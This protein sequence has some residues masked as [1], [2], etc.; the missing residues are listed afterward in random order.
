MKKEP[1]QKKSSAA[2]LIRNVIAKSR[3]PI[4]ARSEKQ[5]RARDHKNEE[6]VRAFRYR[7]ELQL[8]LL[9]ARALLSPSA[10]ESFFKRL[11]QQTIF[12]ENRFGR[13]PI[14]YDSVSLMEEPKAIPLRSEIIWL[15]H[16]LVFFADKVAPYLATA[17]LIQ[18]LVLDDRYEEA[19][20][21]LVEIENQCGV[22]IW[23]TSM[24]IAL[25]QSLGGNDA[26]K[27]YLTTI[28]QL[29]KGGLLR[30]LSI[31]Y[32]QR[33]EGS[34]SIAW[35]LENARRRLERLKPSDVT[36]YATFKVISSWPKINASVAA[37]LRIE[38]NHH[39]FDIYETLLGALQHLACLPID[40]ALAGAIREVLLRLD[41]F[42]DPRILK[43][44]LSMGVDTKATCVERSDDAPLSLLLAGKTKATYRIARR[45][46]H[47][48]PDSAYAR[49]VL[50]LLTS[51]RPK[52][53]RKQPDA[54][55]TNQIDRGLAACVRGSL[56]LEG[57]SGDRDWIR[58]FGHVF[59]TLPMPVAMRFF[60]E[61]ESATNLSD[62]HANMFSSSLNTASISPLDLIGESQRPS[63]ASGNITN[64]LEPSLAKTFSE[65]LTGIPTS[66]EDFDDEVRSFA[67]SAVALTNNNFNAIEICLTPALK[68]QSRTI[69]AHAVMLALDAYARE[70]DLG[71]AAALISNEH[72]VYGASV[73]TL[74][75][76]PVF[77]GTKWRDIRPHAGK[78]DMSI[79][80]YLYEQEVGSDISHTYRC[81]ALQT[82]LQQR[83]LKK[84]SSLR[85]NVEE[86]DPAELL[87][88]LERV[89]DKSVLDMLPSIA[90]SREVLEERRDICALLIQLYG[91]GGEYEQELLEISRELIVQQGLQ[92]ID[93][94]RVHIDVISL[95]AVARRELAESFSRYQELNR[96]KPGS[97]DTFDS[98]LRDM[99]KKETQGKY[100]LF[101]PESE[102]DELLIS[103]ITQSRE[104]FLFD[105]HHGLDS[106][107][108]KRVRHGSI[109]G[110]LRAPAEKDNMITQQN[111]SGV[112]AKNLRWAPQVAMTNRGVE[113]ERALTSFS[114]AFDST[115]VRLKDVLLHV[116][117]EAHPLGVFDAQINA[118]MYHLIR[119]VANSDT[120][121]DNFIETIFASLRGMLNPSLQ[122]AAN[123]V[124]KETAAIIAEQF[125]ALRATING[126][127]PPSTE[128]TEMDAAAGRAATNMHAAIGS[129]AAWFQPVNP[130]DSQY[131]MHEVVAIAI[132]SVQA[133][134][135]EFDPDLEVNDQ[136]NLKVDAANMLVITDV[137]FVILGN[138]AE[139]SNHPGSPKVWVDIALDEAESLVKIKVANEIVLETPLAEA[140]DRIEARKRQLLNKEGS[141]MVRREGGSGFFKLASIVDQSRSA[142]L[143][144]GYKSADVFFVEVDLS[145]SRLAKDIHE[146]SDS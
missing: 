24:H 20:Q 60:A 144:F 46:I 7:R 64:L 58:K 84:P 26:Q 57:S 37:I 63:S 103:M 142:K 59:E 65:M 143:D 25:R 33:A 124:K 35:Y 134:S 125:D 138:I 133:I 47:R 82:F 90:S 62:F 119:T 141:E 50:A 99:S 51:G 55:L 9:K 96:A 17:K 1:T 83:G 68:A 81:F 113:L 86:F 40:E 44:C 93:R 32:S 29:Q 107:L 136:A 10:I 2:A 126:I 4:R 43:L 23:S 38:Q 21:A 111:A 28:K 49:F 104:R 14:G 91:G 108:S 95:K 76:T 53:A 130:E 98:V 87:F 39:E 77:E 48:N 118:P 69:A 116:K 123:I 80:L 135:N 78:I 6:R 67:E 97:T 131:W 19:L 70:G 88:F 105:P 146:N 30:Y 11:K 92:A 79:A 54:G 121:L 120:S 139:R 140:Q 27:S 36:D 15:S 106:Y 128:R 122:T 34:V 71:R 145:L 115:L 22:S 31:F 94:S 114:K 56:S 117:S 8:S 100:L 16:R 41:V 137:L 74:A 112:Y 61:A 12:E 109:V 18:R 66:S 42:D 73:S 127:L 13:Q 75:I 110:Y 101:M 89:C 129:V 45:A 72:A 85:A 52:P 102:A 5:S 3:E 132:A